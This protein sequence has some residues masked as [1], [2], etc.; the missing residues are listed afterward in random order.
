M[1]TTTSAAAIRVLVTGVRGK[2]GAPLAELLVARRGVEVRGGTSDP[3]GPGVKG[4]HPT[5]FSW[6][7][8]VRVGGG[9]R[10]CRRGLRG[11]ARGRGRAGTRRRAA[12]PDVARTEI[13]LLPTR[14]AAT[15]R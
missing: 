14:T 15:R 3:S 6:D 1:P 5:A 10:R 2:T 8:S 4:V 12:G 9:D 7:E 11:P 13:V